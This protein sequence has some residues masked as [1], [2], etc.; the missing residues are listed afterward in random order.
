MFHSYTVRLVALLLLVGLLAG[1]RGVQAQS[2]MR[3][4]N[5]LADQE[6]AE[7]LILSKSDKA[8][9]ITQRFSDALDLSP[10]Q[11]SQFQR[12]TYSHLCQKEAAASRLVGATRAQRRL[13]R[14][15][16]AD[17]SRVLRSS[18]LATFYWLRNRE[19]LALFEAPAM[20]KR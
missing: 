2:N 15:Y 18:Q 13:D 19:P 6:P 16:A 10:M 9:L 14:Q 5:F 3:P 17:L 1:T 11:E 20:A 8:E 4:A 12:Y 7:P